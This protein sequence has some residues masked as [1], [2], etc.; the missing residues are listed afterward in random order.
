MGEMAN[1]LI[2]Q[3]ISKLDGSTCKIT[4]NEMM[5]IS[6]D[7]SGQSQTYQ[8]V[9]RPTKESWLIKTADGKIATYER[10]GERLAVGS[11]GD[12]HFKAYFKRISQ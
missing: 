11:S 4:Q 3:L 10:D 5:F 1:M 7:G 2:P 9:D 6:K 12:V 8:I